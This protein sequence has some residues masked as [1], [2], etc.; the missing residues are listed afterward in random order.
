[1]FLLQITW[2]GDEISQ[3]KVFTTRTL[4]TCIVHPNWTGNLRRANGPTDLAEGNV[5]DLKTDTDSEKI[6][7][8][9]FWNL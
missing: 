3:G 7:R 8:T 1:M 2:K 6:W 4:W 9:L 5:G